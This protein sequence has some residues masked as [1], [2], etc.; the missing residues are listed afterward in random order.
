[1]DNQQPRPEQG[2]V[3][4][5]SPL[6]AVKTATGVGLKQVGENPLNRKGRTIYETSKNYYTRRDAA[7]LIK[8]N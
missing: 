2:K 7:F 4:R 8:N 5:L 3:Q 6:W 1:M